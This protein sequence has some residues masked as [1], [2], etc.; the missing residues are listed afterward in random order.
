M[1]KAFII[2]CTLFLLISTCSYGLMA[3]EDITATITTRKDVSSSGTQY[4][5]DFA[6]QGNLLKK[7][8]RVFIRNPFWKQMMVKNRFDLNTMSLASSGMNVEEFSRLFPQGNYSILLLPQRPKSL[9][10]IYVSHDFPNIPT[11]VYPTDNSIN[12]TTALT[13]EWEDLSDVDVDILLLEIEGAGVTFN[14]LLPKNATSFTLPLNLL[15]PNTQ[16]K[17]TL[18]ARNVFENENSILESARIITFTT[19]A[20]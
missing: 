2:C 7:V 5:I 18:I 20:V 16:Y 19:G 13:I 11:M 4:S 12:V 10:D 9:R 15:Q 8:N 6:L 14:K 1:K 17:L 3:Q